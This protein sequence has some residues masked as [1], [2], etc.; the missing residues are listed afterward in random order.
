MPNVAQLVSRDA[1]LIDAVKKII[2]P[3]QELQLEVQG[4]CLDVLS[5]LQREEI[6]VHLFHLPVQKDVRELSHV[7]KKV[8]SSEHPGIAMV[9]CDAYRNDQAV[10]LLRAGATDYFEVKTDLYKLRNSLQLVNHSTGARV[11]HHGRSGQSSSPSTAN[12]F[13]YLLSP[14]MIEMMDQVRRVAPQSTTLFL[15]GETGT[16]KTQLAKLIHELS[17]RRNEPFLVVDCGALSA[18]LME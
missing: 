1:G 10:A 18:D 15:S 14:E 2:H 13:G 9:L 7:V 3:L 6:A 11:G 4:D 17:P 8:A 5:Q 16:G 12:P